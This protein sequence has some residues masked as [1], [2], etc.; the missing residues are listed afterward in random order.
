[1]IVGAASFCER[2]ALAAADE[3]MRRAASHAGERG[4]LL[5]GSDAASVYSTVPR[6]TRRG[7][8]AWHHDD[9]R[10]WLFGDAIESFTPPASARITL[11]GIVASQLHGRWLAVRLGEG[12][13][14][15]S[16]ATDRLGIAWLYVMYV[17]GMCLFASDFSALAAVLGARA[18]VDHGVATCELALGHMPGDRTIFEQIVLAPAGAIFTLESSGLRVHAHRATSYGVRYVADTRASKFDRLERIYDR[19]TADCVSRHTSGLA[20]SI[21]AGLDSRYGLA[22]LDRRKRLDALCT[23]GHPESDEVRGAKATCSVVG[24]TND[25]FEVPP[26]DWGQ[27]TRAIQA[28]GNC[29]M[30]QWSGWAES[31]LGFLARHG[32]AVMIGYLG[33]ALTGKHI[34]TRVDHDDPLAFWLRFHDVEW[35]TRSPLLARKRSADLG[36]HLRHEL[37]RRLAGEEFAGPHQKLL[38]LDLYGRQRRWVACQPN[39]LQRSVIPEL[40]FYD[41]ELIDFWCNLPV[42]DLLQQRLYRDFATSRF[43]RLFRRNEGRAPGLLTRLGRRI[44]RTMAGRD[45][46]ERHA[47]RVPVIDHARILG[48][49]RGHILELAKRVE[50]LARSTIDVP[51]FCDAIDRYDGSS[52]VVSSMLM[53]VVNLFLLL[54][55]CNGIESP[56]ARHVEMVGDESP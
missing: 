33:D 38:H 3:V 21:S 32:Q 8:R 37:E 40:F 41:E 31:W 54:D 15:L 27:W 9:E 22:Y 5:H 42:D 1:M 30:T 36:Q 13:R 24:A 28:L 12:G 34:G 51:A 6:A 18:R 39:W 26:A 17:D 7:P 53:R 14:S 2:S 25:I 23:F 19:I 45:S 4:E 55:L 46:G 11:E 52:S 49:N 16:F 35:W 47:T 44:A 29:G 43:P 20:L 56:G 48:P 50:P 10:V